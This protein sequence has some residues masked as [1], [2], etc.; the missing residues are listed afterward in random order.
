MG[1]ERDQFFQ[2]L[3]EHLRYEPVAA[4]SIGERKVG[5]GHPVFII[6]EVG[7]NHHSKLE[8]ALLSINKAAAAGADAVKF[9]HLTH[10]KIAADTIVY[11]QWHGKEIGALSEFYRSAELPPDWTGKLA[12][13]ADKHGIGF[14]STPFDLEA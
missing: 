4:I 9:Q 11:D 12:E 7:A 10:D 5:R 6:A 2:S 13:H 14:L 3:P 1:K 8:H